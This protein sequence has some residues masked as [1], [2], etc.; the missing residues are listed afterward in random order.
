M[1]SERGFPCPGN[2]ATRYQEAGPRSSARS[3]DAAAA[4]PFLSVPT[5]RNSSCSKR[6]AIRR[7]LLAT[8]ISIP[9]RVPS[10]ATAIS[11]RSNRR[12]RAVR[13]R[14]VPQQATG[15]KFCRSR[16]G[17]AA[18]LHLQA[19]N[20]LRPLQVPRQ[21]TDISCRSN[22]R[23]RAVR[24]RPVPQQATGIKFCRSRAGQ[25][26]PLRL[27]APNLLRPLQVPR[28]AT[29]ISCRS[30]P[31]SRAVRPRPVPPQAPVIKFCRSRAGLA[32]PLHL[33]APNLLRPL[34]VP[35]QAT[36]ISCRSNPRSRAVRPRPVPPQATVIKFCRS[37]AGQAAPLRLQ[38][39]NLLPPWRVPWLA[40]VMSYPNIRR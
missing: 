1:N 37:R 33:Q 11:C 16:A 17:Q 35:R 13:P 9:W 2:G 20:L 12:S 26:A 28:Q 25:A 39:P 6:S 27:Q 18:P 3:R 15:I 8:D 10:G 30:K 31:R 36:D 34:Q 29:D 4:A 14:P 7:H 19:P 32:A 5:G 23:S 38:A 21:A 40:T 24:P 22:R